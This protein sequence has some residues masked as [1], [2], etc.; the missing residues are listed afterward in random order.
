MKSNV[1]FSLTITLLFVP[2]SVIAMLPTRD[3]I[4]KA[5]FRRQGTAINPG[6][7]PQSC[8]QR[9]ASTVQLFD[10]QGCQT[11]E[12]VCIPAINSGLFDCYNCIMALE[13]V[14]QSQLESSQLVLQQFEDGCQAQGFKLTSLVLSSASRVTISRSVVTLSSTTN[15]S[16]ST[17]SSGLPATTTQSITTTPTPTATSPSTTSSGTS[18]TP[19]TG[20]TGWGEKLSAGRSAVLGVG[21][22][23]GVLLVL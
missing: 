8:T 19:T 18:P 15:S 6:I 3:A 21:V 22:L 11:P 13:P 20:S 17:A 12:C 4:Q 7:I 1:F 14:D 5:V 23:A 16:S 2:T 9:C 10:Q